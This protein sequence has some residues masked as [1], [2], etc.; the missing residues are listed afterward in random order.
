MIIL[1]PACSYPSISIHSTDSL[2]ELSLISNINYLQDQGFPLHK[3]LVVD[4]GFRQPSLPTGVQLIYDNS[5]FSNIPQI[6]EALMTMKAVNSISENI[7]VLK[8]HSRC[9]LLNLAQ[10]IQ[11]MNTRDEFIFVRRNMLRF[12]R[13]NFNKCPF[14]E[15]RL[16]LLKSNNLKSIMNIV[17]SVVSNNIYLE[18]AFLAAAYQVPDVRPNLLTHGNFYP[19]FEGPSGHGVNYSSITSSLKS[20]L[21]HFLYR[22]GV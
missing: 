20:Y 3:I 14:A 4:N 12:S 5:L 22:I 15:T 9:K 8:L 10:L 18:H 2:R 7:S 19:I 21:H 17:S 16:Y 13:S 11:F 6:G 1:L